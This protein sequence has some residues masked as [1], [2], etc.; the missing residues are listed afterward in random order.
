MVPSPADCPSP[1]TLPNPSSFE[2]THVHR[3]LV[4]AGAVGPAGDHPPIREHWGYGSEAGFVDLTVSQ[5]NA[6]P[7]PHCWEFTYAVSSVRDT[8]L[9]FFD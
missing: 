1:P 8:L 3:A 7:F 4:R 9:S 5:D 2:V 6:P